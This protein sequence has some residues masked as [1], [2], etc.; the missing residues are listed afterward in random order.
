VTVRGSSVAEGAL[1]RPQAAVAPARTARRAD[2]RRIM[3][4]GL[5]VVLALMP[6]HAV[7]TVGLG[8]LLGHRSAWQAWKDAAIAGMALIAAWE[9]ARR[10][11]ARERLR[12]W[13]LPLGVFAAICLTVTALQRPA[14]V[15][16]LFGLKVDLEFLV[17]FALAV[18]VGHRRLAERA[19]RIVLA[20]GAAVGVIA[21]LQAYLWPDML[22]GVGYGPTTILPY[23]YVDPTDHLRRVLSTLGGPNQLGE[24]LI[25]PLCLSL[26]ACVRRPGWQHAALVAVLAIALLNSY[27]RSAW[28]GA[29]VA[30][31]V[32]TVLALR[33]PARRWLPAAGGGSV[34]LAAAAWLAGQT[35]RGRAVLAHANAR[36]ARVYDSSAGHMV[37][38]R[39]GLTTLRHHPLGSGLGTAGPASL[40]AGLPVITENYYLQLAIETS[41]LG[42]IAF[43]ALVAVLGVRLYRRRR[44]VGWAAPV[45]G[46]LVGLSVVN[47]FLHG[48]ADTSTALVF[49]TTAGLVVAQG[50]EEAAAELSVPAG[51]QPYS[52]ASSAGSGCL[53]MPPG[54][55]AGSS[56]SSGGGPPTGASPP[57]S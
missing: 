16:V 46:A 35:G 6:F 32:T 20:T 2:P 44:E 27:S 17:A 42:L 7:L 18:L 22:R 53:P 45:L 29:V 8:H 43:A 56:P 34:L 25:L 40:S 15:T 3:A 41:V 49:W 55:Y 47:L 21:I 10:P 52:S 48:W 11:P 13:L 24:F 51:A 57:G 30:I 54:S 50:Q 12:P 14:P 31:A 5:L 37:A 38:L 39:H 9:L 1:G 23:L 26:H 28:L 36:S 4:A 19:V 33:W